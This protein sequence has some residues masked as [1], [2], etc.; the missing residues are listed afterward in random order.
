MLSDGQIAILSD[1]GSS[2]FEDDK[3]GEVEKLIIDGRI[4]DGTAVSASKFSAAA[5]E[6]S[7]PLLRV[8][9]SAGRNGDRMLSLVDF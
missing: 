4:E 2:I 9:V 7:D 1:I 6:G 5:Q 3:H 8:R